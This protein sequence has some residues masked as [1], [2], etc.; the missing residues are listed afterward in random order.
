MNVK[1]SAVQVPETTKIGFLCCVEPFGFNPEE[2]RT[3]LVLMDS[4]HENAEAMMQTVKNSQG[5]RF[6]KPNN[7]P[8]ANPQACRGV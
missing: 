1:K 7:D 6:P 4:M 8:G 2:C 3:A 5:N